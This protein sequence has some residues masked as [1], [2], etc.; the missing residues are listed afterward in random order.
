M[1]KKLRCVV[2]VG[3]SMLFLLK[4]IFFMLITFGLASPFFLFA[5]IKFMINRTII[6]E[7]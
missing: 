3:D 7:I 2:G 4:W 1:Q 6:E 5:I